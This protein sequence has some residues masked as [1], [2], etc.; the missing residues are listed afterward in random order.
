MRGLADELGLHPLAT[1][2]AITGKRA[3]VFGMNF[4][5]LPGIALTYSWEVLLVAIVVIDALMFA[6]FKRRGWL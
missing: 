2:D 5:N 1:L 4:K 3:A 6:N